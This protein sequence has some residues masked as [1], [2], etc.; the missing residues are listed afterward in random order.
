[1]GSQIRPTATLRTPRANSSSRITVAS[2]AVP[3]PGLSQTSAINTGW[4]LA[5]RAR[6][7]ASFSSIC[8]INE[9]S[10][11]FKQF[12]A[13]DRAPVF[14]PWLGLPLVMAMVLVPISGTSPAIKP[15]ITDRES[16]S[17]SVASI[18]FRRSTKLRIGSRD[19]GKI[20]IMRQSNT[21][22]TG[23]I[24]PSRVAT[25]RAQRS[26][27]RSTKSVW[28]ELLEGDEEV[29]GG[30]PLGRQVAVRVDL[31]T[32]E[33]CPDR[34]MARIRSSKSPSGSR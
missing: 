13:R 23:L 16:T 27:A 29:D 9:G 25:A 8:G 12:H 10:P 7:T 26:S 28:G 2:P 33:A 14:G 34:T 15:W 3:P 5:A 6:V 17:L 31:G 1:M 24:R 22:I 21:L 19:V 32:D 4:V 11:L 30:N 18:R 20:S